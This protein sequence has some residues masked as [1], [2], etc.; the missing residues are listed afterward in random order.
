MYLL[1][2]Y[3]NAFKCMTLETVQCIKILNITCIILC[4]L[5]EISYSKVNLH[6]NIHSYEQ[7]EEIT[8]QAAER[9]KPN[10]IVIHTPVH[11]GTVYNL[12]LLLV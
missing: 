5:Q 3:V 9:E 11:V 6:N 7:V 8:G 1:Y 12:H 10:L 2:Y 4:F